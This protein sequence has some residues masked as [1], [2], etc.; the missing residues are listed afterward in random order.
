MTVS[1]SSKPTP[2]RQAPKLHSSSH[3]LVCGVNPVLA[4]ASAQV[5]H[6]PRVHVAPVWVVV[7][8]LHT[9]GASYAFRCLGVAKAPGHV[10]QNKCRLFH[11]FKRSFYSG[12][13]LSAHRFSS[14][15]SSSFTST[16]LASQSSV[17]CVVKSDS[18]NAIQRASSSAESWS[19]LPLTWTS[20]V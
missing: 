7:H 19:P 20:S 13:T 17:M 14:F 15:T 2:S 10:T 5:N 16:I 11:G 9:S 3:L 6:G 1:N 12:T 4:R 8:D 18:S